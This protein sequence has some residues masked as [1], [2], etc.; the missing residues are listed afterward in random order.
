MNTH[1]GG[2]HLW[3][4]PFLFQELP[5]PGRFSSRMPEGQVYFIAG[6]SHSLINGLPFCAF[7]YRNTNEIAPAV[8]TLRHK[9]Q[10]KHFCGSIHARDLPLWV[11]LPIA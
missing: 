9:P 2:D 3:F 5:K 4:L 6:L 11:R 8:H 7:P 1:P 10:P